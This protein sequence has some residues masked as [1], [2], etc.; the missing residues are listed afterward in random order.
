MLQYQR[1]WAWK[2]QQ[3]WLQNRT[4]NCVSEQ[5]S[6]SCHLGSLSG[7][8]HSG[9]ADVPEHLSLDSKCA[10]SFAPRTI[11]K[12]RGN[13]NKPSAWQG[14]ERKPETIHCAAVKIKLL[15]PTVIRSNDLKKN[16]YTTA[17]DVDASYES[18]LT[19]NYKG[20][21]YKLTVSEV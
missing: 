21:S 4:H 8:A 3:S 20:L 17:P 2:G 18:M 14:K 19:K 7:C 6:I 5:T 11:R 9:K 10:I 16:I 12:V 13:P 15:H 1:A